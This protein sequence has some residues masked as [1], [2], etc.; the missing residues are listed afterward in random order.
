[1]HGQYDIVAKTRQFRP[2]LLNHQIWT[3]YLKNSAGNKLVVFYG[4]WHVHVNDS[5]PN[6]QEKNIKIQDVCQ[7]NH[8]NIKIY[9]IYRSYNFFI[10]IETWTV[11]LTTTIL[12][13]FFIIIIIIIIMIW[14]IVIDIFINNDQQ[15]RYN[16][17]LVHIYQAKIISL[18]LKIT[19]YF[20][21]FNRSL[22]K[23][24]IVVIFRHSGSF[25]Y[26]N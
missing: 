23:A 12:L 18:L 4:T 17:P 16:H 3:D 1:M 14:V 9:R 19:I 5:C 20:V 11:N 24:T 22:K 13:P 6:K 10:A 8:K 2:S 21:T 26:F 25:S 15:H 7:N